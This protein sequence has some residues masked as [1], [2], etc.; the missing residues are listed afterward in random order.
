MRIFHRFVWSC[1]ESH[2]SRRTLYR[3]RRLSA[4]PSSPVPPDATCR[5]PKPRWLPKSPS[6]FAVPVHARSLPPP[7][8]TPSTIRLCAT[9]QSEIG[10]WGH[11]ETGR[12]GVTIDRSKKRLYGGRKS[13]IWE[14]RNTIPDHKSPTSP[15]GR[16]TKTVAPKEMTRGQYSGRTS[17]LRNL[18]EVRAVMGSRTEDRIWMLARC[19]ANCTEQ[20]QAR[21]AGGHAPTDQWNMLLDNSPPI[22]SI[23]NNSDGNDE[24]PRVA[25][26]LLLCTPSGL[27]CYLISNPRV[28]EKISP[29]P[30]RRAERCE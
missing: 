30:S 13:E 21:R 8:F 3:E 10:G 26:Q 9:V 12:D 23:D 15:L 6:R 27:V 5:D 14:Y 20:R 25:Q 2:A 7:V 19:G 11:G 17:A 18:A 16:S 22:T 28:S 1:A 29:L 4:T 24:G